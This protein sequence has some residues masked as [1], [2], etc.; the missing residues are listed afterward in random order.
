ML[1]TSAF[2]L[3]LAD[4]IKPGARGRNIPSKPPLTKTVG[5]P[6]VSYSALVRTVGLAQAGTFLGYR[7]RGSSVPKARIHLG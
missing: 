7:Q 4:R 6:N 5:E 3:S 2:E 1:G